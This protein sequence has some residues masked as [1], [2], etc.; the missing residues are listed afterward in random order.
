MSLS[1]LHRIAAATMCAAIAAGLC[2]TASVVAV[3][4]TIPPR[5][6]FAI[7]GGS[8]GPDAQPAPIAAGVAP[9]ADRLAHASSD[10]G[11]VLAQQNCAAC[12]GWVQGA[13]SGVGPNLFGIVGRPVASLTSFQYSSAV[14]ALGGRWSPDRLD[15]WL[16]N[17]QAMAPGTL[18]G[19][20]GLPDPQQR[21]DLIA[22]L[23]KQAPKPG[24]SPANAAAFETLVAKADPKAGAELVAG[25]CSACHTVDKD[26]G[27]GAGP[28]L[29]GV[30]GRGIAQGSDFSYSP[31]LSAHHGTWTVATL[32]EWLAGPQTFAPGTRMGFPG[33]ADPAARANVVAYLKT[34]H[35]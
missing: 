22:F 34:L 17:P 9:I 26:G 35:P 27:P 21:A 31:A 10:Q 30:F 2:A 32:G 14:S 19:F 16:L 5:P 6:A 7:P 15:T 8:G 1:S 3:P 11:A 23:Q 29:W 24:E 28:A 12:H 4:N 20:A 13:P 33:I 18:M 25:Q